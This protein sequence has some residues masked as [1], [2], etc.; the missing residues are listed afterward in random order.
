M[1]PFHVGISDLSF[2]D[3]VR[4]LQAIPVLALKEFSWSGLGELPIETYLE[5]KEP[6]G[7]LMNRL[8]HEGELAEVKR[9]LDLLL[10]HLPERL[11]FS[12]FSVA[13]L[14]EE[15]LRQRLCYKP[16]TVM[17][18]AADATVL[19]EA[20]IP[21]VSVSPLLSIHELEAFCA[22]FPHAE[23]T[24]HGHLL[25]SVSDRHLLS[26][27]AARYGI[28]LP[29]GE[30]SLKETTRDEFF[31]VRETS[32]G[33]LIFTDYVQE[34]FRWLRR[35]ETAGAESFYIDSSFLLKEE[36]LEAL[37][38]YRSLLEGTEEAEAIATYRAAY[39]KVQE[40]YYEQETIL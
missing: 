29:E 1:R 32:S 4:S 25:M 21:S 26:A 3:E 12:D 28:A 18:N 6:Y 14:C 16:E 15:P 17:T 10:T 36:V 39:P 5:T 38:I 20:G 33:F 27:W 8:F 34:S 22:G 11:Y 40:G 13:E 24:I 23:L 9:V 30:L 19:Y 31:P 7:L 37:R 35:L 2:A